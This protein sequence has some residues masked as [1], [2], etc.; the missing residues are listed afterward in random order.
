MP[1]VSKK[2]ANLMRAVAHSPSFAKKVGIPQSVGKDFAAADKGKFVKKYSGEDNQ[3]IVKANEDRLTKTLNSPSVKPVRITPAPS[4]TP[5]AKDM[6]AMKAAKANEDALV[7][8]LNSPGANMKRGGKVKNKVKKFSFGGEL[9]K[10]G[11]SGMLGIAGKLVA[12]DV[13]DSMKPPEE[14]KKDEGPQFVMRKAG[15]KIKGWE[16]SAKD[17]AQDKKLAKKHGMSMS[18]WERSSM[19]KKHD[20]QQSMKGLKSGGY[21]GGG[22]MVKMASGGSVRGDGCASRGKTKGRFC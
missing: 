11:Q 4:R 8:T 12:D 6:A 22:K 17:E 7:K 10:A 16:G 13:A 5:T 14:E 21:C 9:M 2:Q 18:K 3:S 20:K 1:S 15:G 19:D